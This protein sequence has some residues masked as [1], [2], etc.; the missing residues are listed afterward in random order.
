MD[1]GRLGALWRGDADDAY[2]TAAVTGTVAIALRLL[3][4]AGAMDEAYA[5]AG[6]MWDGR[7]RERLWIAV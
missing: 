2:A 7:D 5:E 3:G 1:L 6:R 4:R